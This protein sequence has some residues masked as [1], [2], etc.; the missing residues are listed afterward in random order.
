[1]L[2]IH[3]RHTTILHGRIFKLNL[4]S[5]LYNCALNY[6]EIFTT[7]TCIKYSVFFICCLLPKV[8]PRKDIQRRTCAKLFEPCPNIDKIKDKVGTCGWY[9]VMDAHSNCLL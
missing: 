4:F 3:H 5:F 8:I 7:H 2:K 1:M 6:L 9:L